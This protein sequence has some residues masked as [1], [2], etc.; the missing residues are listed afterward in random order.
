MAVIK[1]NKPMYKIAWVLLVIIAGA[2]FPLQAGLNAKMGKEIA[3]PIWTSFISFTVVAIALLM[4]LLLT[5]NNIHFSGLKTVPAYTWLAGILGSF[6]VAVVV[7]MFPQ[8]GSV[9]TFGLI[10][11]GQL[12]ISLALNHFNVFVQQQHSVN[13]YRVIGIA[14]IIG[15][16]VIIQKF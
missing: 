10:V 7:M 8:L 14:L 9:L 4:Y 2:V 16:V 13:I 3:H 1:T 6:Y 12:I 11:T 15:G 5:K